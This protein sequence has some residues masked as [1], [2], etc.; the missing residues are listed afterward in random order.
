MSEPP[1]REAGRTGRLWMRMLE[2]ADRLDAAERRGTRVADELTTLEESF[3]GCFDP[4]DDFRE[5]VALR[6]CRA[7]RR[8][9]E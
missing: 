9:L 7:L 3:R 4:A 8:H 6:F 1:D 5:Y 2:S